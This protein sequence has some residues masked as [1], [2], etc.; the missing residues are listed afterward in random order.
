[1]K[2]KCKKGII[3]VT[4]LGVL[5]SVIASYLFSHNEIK[6]YDAREVILDAGHGGYD[7]GCYGYS[8]LEKDITLDITMKVKSYLETADIRVTCTREN[9]EIKGDNEIDDLR[10]RVQIANDTN[11]RYFVSIHTNAST[12]HQGNGLELYYGSKGKELVSQIHSELV[13]ENYAKDRGIFKGNHLYVLKHTK[14]AAVLVEVGFLDGKED[15]KT[16]QDSEKRTSIAKRI[17]NGI[18]K[19]MEIDDKKVEA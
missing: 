9:D 12:T 14:M 5:G 19:Q 2:K 3:V 8:M 10:H 17:A 16:L 11:A 13:D 4:T 18:L 6:A 15:Y 1:M 7:P